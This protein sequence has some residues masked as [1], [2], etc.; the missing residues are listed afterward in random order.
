MKFL[1]SLRR[2]PAAGRLLWAAALFAAA[3]SCTLASREPVARQAWQSQR[4]PVVPHG[5]FPAD[6]SLCHTSKNWRELRADFRFDHGRETGVVLQGAHERAEC[7]R[8]HNDRGPVELFSARGCAGCH[9]DP[10]RA[11]LGDSCAV[12]HDELTWRPNAQVAAHARLRFPLVG[13]HAAAACWRCHP[14]AQAGNFAR[15]ETACEACHGDDLAA[16]RAPDHFV[17]GFTERCERCHIPTTWTG[18]GFNHSFW[19]LVGQHLTIRCD[20]CHQSGGYAGTPSDCFT[21]HK[22]HYNSAQNP[23]HV[24]LGLSIHCEECHTP[25]GWYGAILPPNSAQRGRRARLELA[26][27]VLRR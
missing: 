20:D 11:Q 6:C 15:A 4:G 12:C 3:L 21:C 2:T 25:H 26:P 17:Q 10:H 24:A 13:S 5:T 7:L 19:P 14:G 16:A 22:G 18:S 27:E 8:C 9:E 23:D 1:E